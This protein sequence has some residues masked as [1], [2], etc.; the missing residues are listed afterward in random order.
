MVFGETRSF[1]SDA[2]ISNLRRSSLVFRVP[3]QVLPEGKTETQCVGIC[4]IWHLP[5]DSEGSVKTRGADYGSYVSFNDRSE[6]V[7]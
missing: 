5:E 4:L 7:E 3:S 6:G 1:C 2:R